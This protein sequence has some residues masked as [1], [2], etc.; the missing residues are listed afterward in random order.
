MLDQNEPHFINHNGLSEFQLL[1]NIFSVVGR[2]TRLA[3]KTEVITPPASPVRIRSPTPV[4]AYNYFPV[5]PNANNSNY[6]EDIDQVDVKP[7]IKDLKDS[8]YVRCRVSFNGSL[9]SIFVD[10]K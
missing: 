7:I 6:D 3:V 1:N 2:S 8:N 9:L 5:A 10:L 4:A